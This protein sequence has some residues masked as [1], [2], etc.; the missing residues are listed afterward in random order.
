MGRRAVATVRHYRAAADAVTAVLFAAL[1]LLSAYAS[2]HMARA[3]DPLFH[4]PAGPEVVGCIL[5]VTL[6]LAWRRRFPLCA[7]AA[8]ATAFVV[9]YITLRL[10]AETYV[11]GLAVMLALYSAAV[12]AQARARRLV[13]ALALAALV[14]DL[15][16]VVFFDG[17]WPTGQVLAQSLYL[18]YQTIIIVLPWVLGEAIRSLRRR[19]R[20]LTAQADELRREREDN[21]RRAVF[22]ERVR[23]AREL[24]DVVAHHVSVMGVQAGAARTVLSRRPDQAQAAL[25]SIEASSRQAVVELHRLLGFLRRSGEPDQLAP[26]PG[27][28]QLEDLTREVARGGLNVRLS[29]EGAP[30]PLPP[31][32]ELSAYRVIQEAL[33]NTRKH[34]AADCA[35]VRVA[36]LPAA[37][38]I[39]VLDTGRRGAGSLPDDVAEDG[40]AAAYAGTGTG[41]RH[42]LTGMRERANLHG[43]HLRAGPRPPG[44][45]AVHASFPLGEV[46]L[47]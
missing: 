14:A 33:T 34:S 13:L 28:A 17:I 37:L 38:E 8:T 44:G 30:R 26:Q 43:G 18:A 35:T 45:F 4:P 12:H 15:T 31:T 23:I 2:Y 5:G 16:H 1:A 19:G 47:P 20:E 40:P 10:Q 21:A 29:V 7:A 32:L 6:P 39:E 9:A 46:T 24:H 42:G 3:A 11:T 27:L 25:S 41:N 22:E 36:Y